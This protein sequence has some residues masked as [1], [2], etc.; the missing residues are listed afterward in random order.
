[1]RRFYLGDA[2]AEDAVLETVE[3]ES[4]PSIDIEA[5]S[6]Q[7]GAELFDDHATPKEPEPKAEVVEAVASN[8]SKPPAPVTPAIPTPPVLD[9]NAPPKSWPKDM[10]QHWTKVPKEV[11][12]Y[13]QGREKQ[14]LDGLEQYK[15]D[16]QV[17][18]S[19]NKV[20][21]P[22]QAAIQAAGTDAPRAVATLLNAHARLTTGTMESRQAAYAEL[23]RN[24]NLTTQAVSQD[25]APPVD[26][27]IMTLEQRLQSMEQ[28]RQAQKQAEEQARYEK[29][30]AEVAAFAADP[31]HPY[32]DEVHDELM[33]FL[34]K[35]HSLQDAYDKAVRANAVTYEKQMQTRIQTETEKALERK[36]LD[37]LPKQKAR[38]V[39]VNGRETQRTPTEPA[40]TM[41]DTLRSTFRDIKSR[42][43]H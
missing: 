35:G 6:D 2:M 17:G 25:P 16:A 36:R 40:G 30:S 18:Q 5:V 31:A 33:A 20:L 23:G 43:S 24:L 29:A 39:N 32:F 12:T 21:Q 28:E 14:F 7:I 9:P 38:G 10:H 13:Y 27:R 19:I 3:P 11:Q 37:A 1:M 4:T 8:G 41:E 15:A 22:F 42:T 26:P 34:A